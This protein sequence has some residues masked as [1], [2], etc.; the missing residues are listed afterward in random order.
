M[1]SEKFEKKAILFCI[2]LCENS[3]YRGNGI[4]QD[5]ASGKTFETV[6]SDF[7]IFDVSSQRFFAA[8]FLRFEK[9]Y[10]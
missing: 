4:Q 5:G 10:C 8:K 2:F 1:F 9:K 6:T 3:T 7:F